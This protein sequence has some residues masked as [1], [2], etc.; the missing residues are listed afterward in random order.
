MISIARASHP[1]KNDKAVW[2][3]SQTCAPLQ[4]LSVA[5]TKNK[6]E[7]NSSYIF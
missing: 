1:S 3:G 5:L 7:M 4:W 2:Q 6:I